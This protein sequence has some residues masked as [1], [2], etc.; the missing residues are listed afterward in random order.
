MFRVGPA[1]VW[2]NVIYSAQVAFA[3]EPIE[4][5]GA[6][7]DVIS[8]LRVDPG[9]VQLVVRAQVKG[10]DPKLQIVSAKILPALQISIADT[11]VVGINQIETAVAAVAAMK[12]SLHRLYTVI[13][14]FV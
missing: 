6:T 7:F 9:S 13:E 1:V 14:L 10:L 4:Q 11:T 8:C 3:V 12:G 2:L 5:P